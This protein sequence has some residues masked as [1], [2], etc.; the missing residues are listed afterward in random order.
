MSK[1]TKPNIQPPRKNRTLIKG[2]NDL[3]SSN[4]ELAKELVSED[5]QNVHIGSNK[6]YE[7]K[8]SFCGKVWCATIRSRTS[9][10]YPKPGCKDCKN[11]AEQKRKR[12]SFFEVYPDLC[13]ELNDPETGKEVSQSSHQELEWICERGHVYELS[14]N[15]RLEGRGCPYC[16]FAKVLPGFNDLKTLQPSLVSELVSEADGNL[17]GNSTKIIEW[18]HLTDAGI[19]HRW[20]ASVNSRCYGLSGCQICTGSQIQI[21]V[22]DF[23]VWVESSPFHWSKD[24]DF[25]PTDITLGSNKLVILECKKHSSI[26]FMK[27]S[28]KDFVS[29]KRTCTD[30]GSRK[31]K[32]RSIGECELSAFVKEAF[33]DLIV[34]D[35]VRR[36]RKEGVPEI[37]VF[38]EGKIA[39]DFD[40][41]YWHQEGVFKPEGYHQARAISLK[42]LGFPQFVVNEADW[43]SSQS[44]VKSKL[45]D[46]ITYNLLSL[47]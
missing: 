30:C 25:D 23:G 44:S 21:G 16:S 41:T 47:N 33:P 14:P 32:F 27:S 19:E 38:V 36:F 7:W 39:I 10:Y 22:N 13:E 12:K 20:F 37:D 34:E 24:N 9:A 46:F 6:K 5:P 4:I 28:A 2:E 26:V 45:T 1:L 11:P 18:R 8:C 40:G 15:K 42:E 17:I 3:E 43:S 35:N 29:G 31:D